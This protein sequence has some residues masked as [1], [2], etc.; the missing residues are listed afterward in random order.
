MHTLLD[1]NEM[2]DYK[3][4]IPVRRALNKLGADVRD[5]RRRRRI[6]MV[7]LSERASISRMTL[8]QIEKGAPGVSLGNYAAVLFALGMIERLSE[9]ADVRGDVVGLSLEDGHLPKRVRRRTPKRG[10]VE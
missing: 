10:D 8:T 2:T 9:L 6:P 7:Q 1:V 4:P 3:L 5:A